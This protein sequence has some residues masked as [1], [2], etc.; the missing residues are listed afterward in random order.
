MP[1]R[2]AL[3]NTERAVLEALM[4]PGIRVADRT[5]EAVARQTGLGYRDVSR[6]LH[7]L[8]RGDRPLVLSQPEAKL[9]LDIW[10]TTE[11]AAT[12]ME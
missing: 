1:E 2:R 11:A 9:G 10:R 7:D 6:A 5:V 8:A 12:A 3:S 4:T